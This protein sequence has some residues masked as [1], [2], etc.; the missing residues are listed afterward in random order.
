[1]LFTLAEFKEHEG[2]TGSA[3]DARITS[4]AVR[5]SALCEAFCN[6]VLED[7]GV[8]VTEYYDG[9]GSRDLWLK[10]API[11]SIASVH[12]S[13]E[14]QWNDSTLVPA[15]QYLVS[16]EEGCLRLRASSAI[17]AL[18]GSEAAWPCGDFNLRVVYRAGFQRVPPAL[19]EAAIAWAQSIFYASRTQGGGV[20]AR[21]IGDFSETFASAGSSSSSMPAF[22]STVLAKFKLPLLRRRVST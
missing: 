1:M 2:I 21:T 15:D 22:V 18:F 4:L 8:N 3:D 5:V 17:A 16:K 9:D 12:Q 6:R 13:A 10:R 19:K 11:V 14:G 20:T 7:S